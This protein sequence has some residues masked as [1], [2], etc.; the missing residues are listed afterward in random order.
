MKTPEELER[1]IFC[2]WAAGKEIEPL[3]ESIQT[4]A[5]NEAIEAAVESAKAK[6]ISVPSPL[7]GTSY[8]KACVVIKQSILK[9]KK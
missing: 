3:I 1:K 2:T 6:I 4:E 7:S 8:S 5:W 9:L